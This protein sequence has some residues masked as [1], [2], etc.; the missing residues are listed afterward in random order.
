MTVEQI[1]EIDDYEVDESIEVVEV[2]SSKKENTTEDTKVGA[3]AEYMIKLIHAA[4]RSVSAD[5]NHTISDVLIK[6]GIIHMKSVGHWEKLD[7]SQ[8]SSTSVNFKK[9]ID[10]IRAHKPDLIPT[11]DKPSDLSIKLDTGQR[12]RLHLFLGHGEVAATVRLLPSKIKTYE[13]LGFLNSHV[14]TLKAIEKHR[15]GL[16]LISGPTGSGKTS[17]LA[18]FL[19]NLNHDSHL[20]I[21][22]IENPIEYIIPEA[23]SIVTQKEIG[24]D[25][26]DFTRAIDWSLRETPNVIVPGE[27]REPEE[28][29]Q[30]MR[31][32]TSG[33]L[34]ATTM[35]AS[36]CINTLRALFDRLD[37]HLRPQATYDAIAEQLVAIISQL[38]V[39]TNQGKTRLIYEILYLQDARC[40]NTYG[41]L[42]NGNFKDLEP[43]IRL[44]GGKTLDEQID[45]MIKTRAI[46]EEEINRVRRR[47]KP[48]N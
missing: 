24:V 39:R 34:A 21:L 33:H 20:H 22:T 2:V 27:S 26:P 25:A 46:S 16:I 28:F 38:L 40:Q 1:K 23:K 3:A 44:D 10:T 19:N 7:N 13:Q 9:F 41:A 14:E 8:I 37:G 47:R 11:R 42:A 43:Y 18:T 31:A 30:V 6:N 35:H 15:N 32:A 29:K 48:S 12:A 4:L 36:G 17:T 45:Q 5:V